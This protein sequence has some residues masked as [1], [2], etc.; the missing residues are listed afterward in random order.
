VR[1]RPV[2]VFWLRTTSGRR[3]AKL[4]CVPEGEPAYDDVH[5][6]VDLPEH[7]RKEIGNFFDV[8][9]SLDPSDSTTCDGEDGAEAAAAVIAEAQQRAAGRGG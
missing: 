4:L 8:Y 1:A 7:L 9:R 6:L 2:G 3:E 5:D